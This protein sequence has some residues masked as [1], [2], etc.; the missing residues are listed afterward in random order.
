LSEKLELPEKV[1]VIISN[2]GFVPLF[3]AMPDAIQR[4]LKPGGVTMPHSVQLSLVPVCLDGIYDNKVNAWKESYFGLTFS[5]FLP[6]ATDFPHAT[7]IDESRFL[8]EPQDLTPIAYRDVLE[9]KNFVWDLSFTAEKAGTLHG[10][11]AWYQFFLTQQIALST[12]PPL[13]LDPEL[14]SHP[15]FPLREAIKLKVGDVVQVHLELVLTVPYDPQ[16]KWTI[17]VNGNTT[18]QDTFETLKLSVENALAQ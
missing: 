15:F 9:K 4:F 7:L 2:V 8:A 17:Q 13:S 16:W 14:W 11:N 5:S 12:K 10:I 6:Y 18:H 1:D 3:F